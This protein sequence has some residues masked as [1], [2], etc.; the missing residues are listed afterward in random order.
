[1]P[2]LYQ[3]YQRSLFRQIALLFIVGALCADSMTHA[4]DGQHVI[5]VTGAA[6]TPEY[7]QMFTE[8]ADRW[9]AAAVAGSA[10]FTRVGVG[11]ETDVLQQLQQA[12]SEAISV[13]TTEPLWLVLIGHGT[14]DGRIARFNLR[15]P[16]L[17]AEQAA[18]M[19]QTSQRPLAIINCSSSS[20]PF[21]NQ[22]SGPDRTV[23]TATKEGGEIQFAR[24]GGF[25][26][27]A[28]GGLEADVDR[29]GQ[30]SLL[31]AWLFSVRQ[32]EQY[33]Q[34]DGRLATE[35]SL[36]DDNGDGQGVRAELFLG[37]RVKESVQDRQV[38]D[39]RLANR[40]HLIRSDAERSLSPEQRTQRDR[41]EEQLEQLR[42]QRSELTEPDYLK[43]LEQI[44]VPLA[45][46]Y[47]TAE[48]V[49]ATSKNE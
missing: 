11:A 36:L 8:W 18:E 6:G 4:D 41:L 28:I 34:S 32:T 1:M 26:A 15:G 39:G 13:N 29:D 25:L 27:D 2:G 40:W 5:V 9:E 48:P 35:H 31:E 37:V 14:F 16:D 24:F 23:I 46:L 45:R 43:Q 30:T 17:S 33:Y 38:V 10:K 12:V 47:Q 3:P 21:I 49:E 22:L 7:G 44:L 19:L 20:A 42:Q